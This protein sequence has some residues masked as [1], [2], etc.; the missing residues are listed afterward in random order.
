MSTNNLINTFTKGRAQL[1][2]LAKVF[3]GND[4]DAEDAVQDAFIRLWPH[5][6]RLNECSFTDAVAV[7]TIKNLAID[8]RRHRRIET[9]ELQQKDIAEMVE[10]PTEQNEILAD[11]ED[12]IR[13]E[14]TTVQRQIIRMR[15]YEEKEY[16]DI[17][18][19]LGMQPTAVRMQLSRAR[20]R[21]REIYKQ[22]NN[23]R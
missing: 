21:I 19:A 18:L 9:K 22:R 8:K 10:T 6:D 3:F 13:T 11:V 14:L 7:K 12:I 4:S 1:Q 20:K 5:I 23:E 2:Q 15:D 16:D 17:A